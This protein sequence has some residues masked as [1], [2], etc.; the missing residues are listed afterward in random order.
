M[1]KFLIEMA[2]VIC[3]PSALIFKNSMESSIIMVSKDWKKRNVTA[4]FK[5][6]PRHCPGNYR[7]VSLT[8]HSCKLLEN[9]IRDV[10]LNN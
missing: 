5:R 9:I 2:D 8:S 6:G 4:V 3:K 1:P 7:P 10:I